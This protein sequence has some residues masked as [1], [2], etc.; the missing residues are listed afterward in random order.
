[1]KKRRGLLYTMKFIIHQGNKDNII[2]N[3][4]ISQGI[5]AVSISPT[6]IFHNSIRYDMKGH[7]F[8]LPIEI[9]FDHGEYKTGKHI[10]PGSVRILWREEDEYVVFKSLPPPDAE[11]YQPPAPKGFLEKYKLFI[12]K[13]V[14][15][16]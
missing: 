10:R 15:R 9:W 12:N 13:K 6:I 11:E 4:E 5:D 1:M 16:R 14:L 8:K 7:T 2:F 3:P